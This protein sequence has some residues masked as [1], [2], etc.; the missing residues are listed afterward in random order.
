MGFDL[1][2]A[3]G[4]SLIWQ[5]GFDVA[6]ISIYIYNIY[7]I[8]NIYIHTHIYIYIIYTFT[9]STLLWVNCISTKKNVS[10]TGAGLV[11]NPLLARKPNFGGPKAPGQQSE[12]VQ[13]ELYI[14]GF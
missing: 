9:Y 1:A 3:A 8:Y 6:W 10:K 5:F 2:G 14:N 12:S 13:V 4:A 7:N 11:R